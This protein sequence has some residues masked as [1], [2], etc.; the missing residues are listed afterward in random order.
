MKF[1]PK[2]DKRREKIKM[3]GV[4]ILMVTFIVF[5]AIVFSNAEASNDERVIYVGISSLESSPAH[6]GINLTW[7]SS[8][9]ETNL[10]FVS[11]HI[12]KMEEKKYRNIVAGGVAHKFGWAEGTILDGL[13]I[14]GGLGLKFDATEKK[15][16]KWYSRYN[17]KDFKVGPCA[18]F[19]IAKYWKFTI[20]TR[21]A[22][23]GFL[24]KYDY[25]YFIPDLSVSGPTGGLNLTITLW[26]ASF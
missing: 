15:D 7:F 18:T 6:T 25:F 14:G 20:F 2:S 24:M 4:S 16:K 23:I 17:Y 3:N 12:V 21:P 5:S 13:H 10:G 26:E 22:T 19:G 11:G 9:E 1:I 8:L